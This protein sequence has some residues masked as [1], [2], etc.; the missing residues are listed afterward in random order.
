MGRSLAT[1]AAA[2]LVGCSIEAGGL[3][4]PGGDA[5]DIDGAIDVDAG[6]PRT[7]ATAGTDAERP[8]RDA[9]PASID[10]GTDSGGPVR[11]DSG[12]TL[13]DD[14]GAPINL[15]LTDN[16]G[17]LE[18]FTSSWCVPSSLHT[19]CR[20]GF[21]LPEN[22]HDGDYAAGRCADQARAAW[23]SNEKERVPGPEEFTFRFDGGRDATLSAIVVQNFGDAACYRDQYYSAGFE[24]ELDD[25]NILA[26]VLEAHTEL[27]RFDLPSTPRGS[28]LVVRVT[29]GCS[30][31][32][33]ELT[34][35]LGEVEAWG[36]LE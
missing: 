35:E 7:D 24:V 23:A 15:L 14:A 13:P 31:C 34:W 18:S 28:E 22:V 12:P 17:V 27:Q 36:T 32:D 5:G 6:G 19:D 9:E 16:G 30:S 33:A 3:E 10:A 1:I 11:I 8:R 26:V 4:P 20:T 25:V 29:S 2:W 21:Y